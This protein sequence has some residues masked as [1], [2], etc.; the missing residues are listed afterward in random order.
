MFYILKD[1]KTDL[2]LVLDPTGFSFT[3]TNNYLEATTFSSI[4]SIV[5]IQQELLPGVFYEIKTIIKN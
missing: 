3:Y 5:D 4:Q 1:L 2:Y